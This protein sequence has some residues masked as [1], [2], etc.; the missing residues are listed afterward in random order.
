MWRVMG[1]SRA[2]TEVIDEFETEKEARA[3]AAEYRMAFGPSFI[4]WV[5]SD[6]KI[7]TGD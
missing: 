7:S 1:K 3:M 2:G 5:E 6:T 4:I